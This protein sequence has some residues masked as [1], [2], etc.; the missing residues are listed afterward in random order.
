MENLFIAATKSSPEINFDCQQHTL[1][2]R[3]ESYPE[4]TAEFYTPI[5]RWI[6]EYLGSTEDHLISIY[7]ELVYFNSS[8]AKVLMDLFDILDT[9]A[10]TGKRITINWVYD[11][12]NASALEAGEEFQE[13]VEYMTFNLLQKHG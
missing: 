12:R 9:S 13:E 5:L 8:S 6:Q 7:M 11:K 10:K 1:E 4:N 2:I 3:G